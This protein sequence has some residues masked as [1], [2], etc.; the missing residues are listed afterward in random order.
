[1]RLIIVLRKDKVSLYDS[2]MSI[3]SV[4]DKNIESVSFCKTGY[5]YKSHVFCFKVVKFYK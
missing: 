4:V 5:F 2:N 3:I 1:M